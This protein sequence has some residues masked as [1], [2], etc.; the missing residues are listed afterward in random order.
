MSRRLVILHL[1]P[2]HMNAYGDSGNLLVL[3]RRL[4]WRNI[5]YRV[6]SFDIGDKL[7]D[8]VDLIIGGGGQ[9]SDQ[10]TIAPEFVKIAPRLKKW[11]SQSVPGLMVDDSYQ[12]LGRYFETSDGNKI[13]GG[14]IL[15]F[16][17]KTIKKRLVGNIVLESRQFGKIIGYENHSSRTILADGVRPL[18]VVTKGAGNSKFGLSEGVIYQNLIGSYCHGPLLAKNPQIADFLIE[19]ALALNG[20]YNELKPLDDYLE[21]QARNQ[22]A[23]RKR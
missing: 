22:A 1:F 21:V 4:E 6:V 16:V 17:T 15:D 11:F 8:Q 13:E 18:G 5:S 12:L 7:P 2:N 3:K 19:K 20:I 23:K 10:I 14:N 9:K